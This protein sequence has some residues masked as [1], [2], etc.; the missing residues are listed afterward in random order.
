MNPLRL[1]GSCAL[2]GALLL[3]G[4]APA[5]ARTFVVRDGESIQEAVDRASPGDVIRV[6]R[7]VYTAPP[8]REY[9][10]DVQTSG[11]TLIGARDAV[12]DASGLEYGIVVGPDDRARCTAHLPI[13][14]FRL[15]GFTIRDA[16][17]TGVLLTNTADFELRGSR[18]LDS[19]NYGPFP[20]CSVGGRIEGN[21]VAGHDDAAIYVGD[22]RDITV[23][24]NVAIDNTIGV[25]IENTA[26][27]T[28]R[29]NILVGNTGGVLVIAAPGLPQPFTEDVRVEENLILD[30][31]RPNPFAPGP[32]TISTFPQGSGILNIGGDRVVIRNNT[33]LGN[34]SFGVGTIGNFFSAFDPRLEP[35]VDDQEV[36]DN[37]ILGN[38][39]DPDP[40]RLVTPGADILFVPDLIDPVT[41]Q[42]VASDPDPGDN[43][44]ARN[45]FATD[46]PAD[47]VSAFPC[48]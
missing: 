23:V 41:G 36:R 38:G 18:Y 47:V 5:H 48:P 28:V 6:K 44:F 1:F 32:R 45:L 33:I 14:G 26:E 30:N 11:L 4:T 37:V 12:I 17:D 7:G 13:Q 3:A 27:T 16:A 34:G 29:R 43:C 35:F 15:I 19:V 10:V 42:V 9:V 22:D 40:L 31:N 20:I 39:T 8:G 46:F 25:E 24:G 2:L 21:F